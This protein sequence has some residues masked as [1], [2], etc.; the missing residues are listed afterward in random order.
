[1]PPKLKRTLHGPDSPEGPSH[2]RD[3]RDFVKRTLHRLEET[4]PVGDDF[5]PKPPGGFDS[6]Y[7]RKTVDAI[8]QLRKLD[9]RLPLRGPFGQGDLDALWPRADAF[10]RWVYRIWSAPKPK[11]KPVVPELG[12]I[13]EGGASILVHDLT[14]ETDGLP[15]YPAFDDGWVAGRRIIAPE[16]CEVTEQSGSQGGDAFYLCGESSIAYWIGHA[17]ASPRTGRRFRKGETMST[18]AN[19]LPSQGGPHVHCGIDARP[20][21]GR[22]LLHHDDYT[23]GAPT[24]GEQL[25]RALT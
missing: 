7:N 21:I 11:P 24:V 13:C 10:S 23:H 6:I 3:V 18:I 4:E 22:E 1:M 17:S 8:E 2:G 15:G 16:D 25:R 19:I 9:G 20:L 14:H 12:P 5:F